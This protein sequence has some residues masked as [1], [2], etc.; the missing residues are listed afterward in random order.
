VSPEPV[1]A[2]TVDGGR[3]HVWVDRLAPYEGELVVR[4]AD[5][6]EILLRKKV[7]LSYQALFGPDFGDVQTWQDW[8][9]KAIDDSNDNTESPLRDD[10]TSNGNGN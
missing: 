8:A 3:Y 6:D 1:W 9:L 10:E 4:R 7:G 5:D 2:S